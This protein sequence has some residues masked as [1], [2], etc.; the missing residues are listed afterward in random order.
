[1]KATFTKIVSNRSSRE[2]GRPKLIVLHTTEGG[3]HHNDILDIASFFD[4]P[5]TQASA[6]VVN[7]NLGESCR[8][9]NDDEKSWAVCSYNPYTLNLEQIGFASFTRKDWFRRDKQLLNSAAWC[10][11]WSINH[12]IPLR[13]GLGNSSSLSIRRSGIVQHKD[14]GSV[15]CGH[16]DCG[17]GY[18]QRYVTLVARLI[19]EEH[20]LGR[21]NSG[22]A[23]RLR[24]IL[25]VTRKHYGLP[26]F[27]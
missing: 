4:Q 26:P 25:N 6:H 16:S 7:N 24:K 19:V 23:K 9:V 11:D 5:S 12:S 1:M 10:A 14:L 27:R 22:K 15:G 18:P 20:H 21:P 3:D 8:M 13:H 2:G 17:S